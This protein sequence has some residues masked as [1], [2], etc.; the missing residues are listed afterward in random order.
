M[1]APLRGFFAPEA[2]EGFPRHVQTTPSAERLAGWCDQRWK[3]SVAARHC[4]MQLCC[5]LFVVPQMEGM[6]PLEYQDC[7]CLFMVY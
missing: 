2:V 3:D 7:I 1:S 6:G 4:A 5:G